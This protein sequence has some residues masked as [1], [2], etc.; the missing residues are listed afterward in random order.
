M[1]VQRNPTNTVTNG[2]KKIGHDSQVPVL[3]RVSFQEK[4]LSF[5]PGGDRGS[6]VSPFSLTSGVKTICIP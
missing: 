3:T 6:T 2:P 4:V 5:L 1:H